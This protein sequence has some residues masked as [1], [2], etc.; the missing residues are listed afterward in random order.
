MRW[1]EEMRGELQ[2]SN[3]MRWDE[4]RRSGDALSQN[5]SFITVEDRKTE[6]SIYS[7]Q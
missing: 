6:E 7:Y 1:D 3:G 2:R 4:E 5:T